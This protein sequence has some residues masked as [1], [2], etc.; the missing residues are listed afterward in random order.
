MNDPRPS[1]AKFG[2]CSMSAVRDLLDV[3]RNERDAVLPFFDSYAQLGSAYDDLERMAT[4]VEF[5]EVF[6][7]FNASSGALSLD[8]KLEEVSA[9][10]ARLLQLAMAFAAERK[11][12][13]WPELL[14]QEALDAVRRVNAAIDD[15]ETQ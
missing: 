10:R 8:R 2:E 9:A 11:E 15:V 3:V 12:G 6:T 14:R 13:K 5:H 4:G 7:A 1:V